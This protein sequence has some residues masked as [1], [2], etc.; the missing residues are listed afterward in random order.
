MPDTGIPAACGTRWVAGAVHRCVVVSCVLF[1]F[2]LC[3][4]T[5]FGLPAG[6]WNDSRVSLFP[7]LRCFVTSDYRSILRSIL[8]IRV[9]G[10]FVTLP[11]WLERDFVRVLTTFVRSPGGLSVCSVRIP[12]FDLPIYR[13]DYRSLYRGLVPFAFDSPFRVAATLPRTDPKFDSLFVTVYV[14]SRDVTPLVLR[15]AVLLLVER[16]TAACRYRDFPDAFVSACLQPLFLNS[17]FGRCRFPVVLDTCD[18]RYSSCA[19]LF[20]PLLRSFPAGY[21]VI[22]LCLFGCRRLPIDAHTC[23]VLTLVLLPIVCSSLFVRCC[24]CT[25]PAF[26]LRP[27]LRYLR[28]HVNCCNVC[29]LDLLFAIRSLLPLFRT[30]L[31]A[32]LRACA[33]LPGC[34]EHR[35]AWTALPLCRSWFLRVARRFMPRRFPA[36]SPLVLASGPVV[37][38]FVRYP[39]FTKVTSCLVNAFVGYT[40][41]RT[42]LPSVAL[43]ATVIARMPSVI[44]G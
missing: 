40:T 26:T 12:C 20:L 10:A 19:I 3:C 31:P 29:V 14:C 28:F 25:L 30:L 4:S 42:T 2:P 38:A 18:C 9:T 17:F 37:S 44:S 32:V 13:C 15:Y 5:R 22:F 7:L 1:L 39:C 43:F 8:H 23:T 24:R 27:Y 21:P 34:S 41:E 36:R 35:R 16:V 11:T 33:G 6:G